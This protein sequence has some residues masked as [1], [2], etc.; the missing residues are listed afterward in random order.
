MTGDDEAVMLD[1]GFLLIRDT[2]G[3]IL[4]YE[5]ECLGCPA[6]SDVAGNGRPVA[7]WAGV[8]ARESGHFTFQRVRRDLYHATDLRPERG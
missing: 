4:V 2:A 6:V 3:L 8:H 7:E 1:S 5:A